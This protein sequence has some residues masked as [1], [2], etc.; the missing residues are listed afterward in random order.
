M[1]CPYC[2]DEAK[3]VDS[4]VIYRRSYG[5]IWLCG[6]C[7]AYVGTHK[8]SP[9]H[10]PLGRLANKALRD[11]KMRAHA[12]FDPLWQGKMRRDQ[13][14]KTKARRAAYTW[15]AEQLGIEVKACHIGQ[16]D[17]ELCQRTEAVCIAILN[18]NAT[19]EIHDAQ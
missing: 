18:K 16:F 15:L 11:L 1:L 12:A 13:C 8:N 2:S 6:P 7:D 19:K 17:S 3:L 4:L 5:M 14:S 10:A 9:T